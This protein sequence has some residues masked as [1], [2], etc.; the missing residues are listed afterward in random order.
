M[1]K[2]Y[3]MWPATS[4]WCYRFDESVIQQ[5][6]IRYHTES[7]LPVCLP[8]CFSISSFTALSW[9]ELYMQWTCSVLPSSRLWW[10]FSTAGK[11]LKSTYLSLKQICVA[12]WFST[13]WKKL[14]RKTFVKV[15]GFSCQYFCNYYMNLFSCILLIACI[16]PQLF[17]KSC[18]VSAGENT[19]FPVMLLHNKILK[20]AK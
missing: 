5:C 14:E 17:L 19:T 15:S 20:I 1:Y 10:R 2:I 13:L 18:L 9:A 3:P 8:I 16:D 4:L 6:H 7:I 11:P 12:N